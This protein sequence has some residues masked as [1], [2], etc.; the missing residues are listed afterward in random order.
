VARLLG[1]QSEK[2]ELKVVGREFATA[3][4]AVFAATEAARA[5][6]EST[7]AAESIMTTAAGSTQAVMANAAA[8]TVFA[9]MTVMVA[10]HCVPEGMQG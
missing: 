2:Q 4:H 5:A 9:V 8:E 6:A 10:A 7:A 3:R 1:E